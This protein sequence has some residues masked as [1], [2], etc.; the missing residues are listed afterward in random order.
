ML[1]TIGTWILGIIYMLSIVF[2][3]LG[4]IIR[5]GYWIRCHK[6]KKSCYN[7]KCA[8]KHYCNKY[9]DWLTQ[10]EI[11]EL[12]KLIES[13]KAKLGQASKEEAINKQRKI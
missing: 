1:Y 12:V 5:F 2:V 10:D 3:I 13:Y 7:K 11:D 6:V 4:N 8:Y 9:V